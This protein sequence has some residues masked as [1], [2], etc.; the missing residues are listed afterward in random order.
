[1]KKK[2]IL[3]Y[4]KK[5]YKYGEFPDFELIGY[6]FGMHI[7]DILEIL[8]VNDSSNIVEINSYKRKVLI[9]FICNDL[10]SSKLDYLGVYYDGNDNPH[11]EHIVWKN[12]CNITLHSKIIFSDKKGFIYRG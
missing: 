11:I 5:T 12:G 1:M 7:L 4:I 2:L 10:Y 6:M 8:Y 9:T 3:K